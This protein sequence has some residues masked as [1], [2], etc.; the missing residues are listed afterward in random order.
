MQVVAATPPPKTGLA[1]SLHA[2]FTFQPPKPK[3]QVIVLFCKQL[4]S[5]V[6][7]GIPITD[8]L[9][10]FA[11]QAPN[12]RLRETYS[13]V[14]S[15]LERGVRLSAA[16]GAHPLIFPTIVTDMVRS[17]EMT[18]NLT[19]V[20]R[21]AAKHIEREAAARR[22]IKSAMTYPSIIAVLAVVI[23]IG[24]TLFVL[25][26][27]AALYASLG[28]KPPGI[29]SAMLGIS[30]YIKGHGFLIALGVLVAIVVVGTWVRT[31]RGRM[32]RD[33]LLLK[34]PL[35]G[36]MVRASTTERFTRALGDM[37]TAGV[38]IAQA[39]AV[40]VGTV[41]NRVHRNA[42]NAVGASMAAGQG[43]SHPLQRTGV[44]TSSVIQMIRVGEETGHM[45]ENLQECAD[46]HEDELDYRIKR[47]TAF[48]EPALIV[49][50]GCM[51][52]FVAVTIFTSIY[53]LAGGVK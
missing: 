23:T 20:L 49:F 42:L 30:T 26:E 4:A 14:V 37:L 27:F 8:A 51:V 3:S 9:R 47:M 15:D 16:F 38:P 2:F 28:V 18:G 46:I 34:L 5:F 50:V 17:A 41:R 31:E 36:P 29:L 13:T 21:Q 48:L 7:V 25:P 43:I 44:F 11:E 6:R 32:V 39:Y 22:K 52:G 19:Q 53:S 33:G 35:I 1:A 12:K 24:I 40:V 10:A 45:D